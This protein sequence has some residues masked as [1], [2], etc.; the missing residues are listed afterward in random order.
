M[1]ARTVHARVLQVLEALE[2]DV[3][4][5]PATAFAEGMAA[6]AYRNRS[7]SRL[8]M[9]DDAWE[10]S[11]TRPRFV[12]GVKRV[13]HRSIDGA[14]VPAR[15]HGDYFRCLG[16]S[17]D[18]IVFGVDVVDNDYFAS[19]A[20][21]A[22]AKAAA[23]R[24]ERQLPAKYFLFVGRLLP[25]KGLETLIEAYAA[26]RA[27]TSEAPWELVIVGGGPHEPEVRRMTAATQGVHLPG[28]QFGD[29]LLD[30]Y[31]LAG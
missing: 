27:R 19:G 29:A 1:G 30:C 15:S 21:R 22:R 9:M 2:P 4:F 31:G 23:I 3:V 14:F 20:D 8:F 28:P 10:G 26:Y 7:A 24:A 18:R 6:V 25:R 12:R 16:F 5:A 11:D 13:I 17:G